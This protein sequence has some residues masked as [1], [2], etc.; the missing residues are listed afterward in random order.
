M[1]ITV[2]LARTLEGWE[3][4]DADLEKADTFA[5]TV[6]IAREH[7]VEDGTVRLL[8]AQEGT[9]FGVV[10]V[11]GTDSPG[12]FVSD[13]AAAA[14]TS[15]GAMLTEELLRRA[16]EPDGRGDAEDQADDD[17]ERTP[18]PCGPLGDALLLDSFGT[19]ERELLGLDGD[20]VA[21]VSDVL[22]CTEVLQA[23]R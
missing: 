14:R 3:A 8:A 23:A 2:M 11:D 12:V 16:A 15:F 17:G 20:A 7:V 10:R 18:A 21:A 6:R 5:D 13:A 19:G 4:V 1:H 9:W 22:G